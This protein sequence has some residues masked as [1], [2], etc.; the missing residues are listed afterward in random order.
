MQLPLP[1]KNLQNHKSFKYI[2]ILIIFLSCYMMNKIYVWSNTESTDNAYVNAEIS[3]VGSEINGRVKNVFITDNNKVNAGDIIAE[4][5]SEQFKFNLAKIQ[6]EIS[7][8][9]LDIEAAARNILIEKINFDKSK[10]LLSLAKTNLGINEIS[11]RRTEDLTKDRFSSK[12]VFDDARFALEKARSEYNQAV[13]DAQ[14]SEHKLLL[15]QTQKLVKEANLES[16]K[17][18]EKIAARNLANTQIRSPIAGT[19]ASN[20]LEIGNYVAP[21]MILL[22]VVPHE[23]YIKAN[24]KETQIAKLKIGMKVEI[25]FDTYSKQKVTGT[26]RNFSPATGSKF[27]LLPPDNATGN[28]TKI[29]QRIPVLIDFE[30][31][32]N[33][34]ANV[35]PGMSAQ[36]DIRI[37][38]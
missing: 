1:I 4:I 35:V 22:L 15:N 8:L 11:F 31:P 26:I 9:N 13:L 19:V 28:F 25:K 20:N 16:I 18:S 36:I 37:D 29:V 24:F 30:L 3:L 14:I 23:S 21:G 12:K 7:S 17:Q 27:S 6:A 10:E 33:F 5:D 34:A 2:I 32:K 38:Q